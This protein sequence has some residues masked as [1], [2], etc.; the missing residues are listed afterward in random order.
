MLYCRPNK[1]SSSNSNVFFLGIYTHA[2]IDET[3]TA[4]AFIDDVSIYRIKDILEIRVSNDRD[5]VYDVV[6]AICRIHPDKGNNTLKDW[7]FTIKIKDNDKIIYEKNQELVSSLFT[8][9]IKIKDYDL[10]E[11]NIYHIE[12]IIKSELDN[13]T[14]IFSYP[15]KKINNKNIKRKVRLDEYGRMFINDELFFPFGIYLG[16]VEE[17]DLIQLNKTHLNFILPYSQ[18]DKKTMD[19]VY[20][21]QQGKIKVIYSVKDMYTFDNVTCSDTNEETNYNKF[22][23][24][25]N[26]FK[27]NHALLSWYINDETPACF[28]KN[29]RNRT[30]SIHEI[31]P[32]HPTTTVL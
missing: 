6:N 10:K 19:M 8:M 24:K 3:G 1:K 29:L 25:I 20:E 16:T 31:D 9:P 2:Q 14:D 7:V 18:I 17:K 11:N 28:N 26:Q 23:T 30:L 12:G 21:T 32:N 5:E 15:F 22:V 13:T 27:D 4:E